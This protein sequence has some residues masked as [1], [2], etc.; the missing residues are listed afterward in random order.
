MFAPPLAA[1]DGVMFH[2]FIFL[3]VHQRLFEFVF[4][5]WLVGSGGVG[6]CSFFFKRSLDAYVQNTLT[7]ELRRE[8]RGW[9]WWYSF[10]MP[11]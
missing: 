10:I 7:D 5:H 11:R 3:F 9:S 1:A 6:R 2:Y 4:E 8:G